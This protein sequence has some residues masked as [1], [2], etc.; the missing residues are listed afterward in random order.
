MSHARTG[1]VEHIHSEQEYYVIPEIELQNSIDPSLREDTNAYRNNRPRSREEWAAFWTELIC[2]QKSFHH[3]DIF[4]KSNTSIGKT[5]EN[6]SIPIG[7]PIG[8]SN[9]DKSGY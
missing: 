8:K 4:K 7:I 2:K 6:I 1:E 5:S 3:T 9:C